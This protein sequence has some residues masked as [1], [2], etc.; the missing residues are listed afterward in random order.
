MVFWDILLAIGTHFRISGLLVVWQIFMMIYIIILF[1]M[2]IV[3]PALLVLTIFVS[4]AAA[5]DASSTL[6]NINGVTVPSVSTATATTAAAGAVAVFCL[7]F[8]IVLPIVYIYF[9]I[10][11]NNLRR[12]FSRPAPAQVQMTT[13]P[14]T[15]YYWAK[16]FTY[17]NLLFHVLRN[18]IP[19]FYFIWPLPYKGSFTWHMQL[20]QIV[21]YLQR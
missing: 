3:I 17:D 9:W 18:S 6:S 5:A 21:A 1:A 12:E 19:Y 14:Q 2:W 20:W 7:V 13:Y 4:A 16:H 11:V 8:A 15:T 10:V